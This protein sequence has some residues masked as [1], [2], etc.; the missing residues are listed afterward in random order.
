[1]TRRSLHDLVLPRRKGLAIGLVR[2]S[3]RWGVVAAI[4]RVDGNSMQGGE[5]VGDTLLV[6]SLIQLNQR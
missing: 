2:C 1:M 5:T 6:A 4:G 3:R